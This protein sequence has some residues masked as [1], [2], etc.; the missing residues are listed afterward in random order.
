MP[1]AMPQVPVSAHIRN[2]L[3]KVARVLADRRLRR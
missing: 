1:V 2:C 3:L